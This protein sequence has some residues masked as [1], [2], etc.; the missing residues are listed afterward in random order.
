MSNPV[1]PLVGNNTH[2]FQQVEVSVDDTKELGAVVDGKTPKL[3]DI[4]P[5]EEEGG[6]VKERGTEKLGKRPST[7]GQYDFEELTKRFDALKKR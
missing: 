2:T 4:L 6:D 7:P 3:P 5:A 1:F